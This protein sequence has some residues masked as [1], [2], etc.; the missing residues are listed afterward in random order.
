MTPKPH[1]NIDVGWR[2]Y[3]KIAFEFNYP[4]GKRLDGKKVQA[5]IKRL[6]LDTAET[7]AQCWRD[8]ESP[9]AEKTFGVRG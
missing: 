8:D 3:G 6:K 5:L 7:W 9:Q 2:I 4:A 1:I